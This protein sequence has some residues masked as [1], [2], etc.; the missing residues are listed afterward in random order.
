MISVNDYKNTILSFKGPIN[1]DAVAFYASYLKRILEHDAKSFLKIYKVF[2]ELTQNI[3]YYSSQ[4]YTNKEGINEGIGEFIIRE[5][6]G[7]YELIARNV[8]TSKQAREL[9][10]VCQR[11]NQLDRKGVRELKRKTRV[12]SNVKSKGAHIGLMQTRLISDNPLSIDITE[13]TEDYD[14][15][16]MKSII[17]KQ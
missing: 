4:Y 12:L 3:S 16:S 9:S 8:T 2:V 6:T 5:Y 11:L 14:I 1:I 10:I 15:I 17:N 13:M 7:Y